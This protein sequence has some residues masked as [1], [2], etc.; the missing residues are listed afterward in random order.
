MKEILKL[1]SNTFRENGYIG[2]NITIF[3]LLLEHS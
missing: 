1:K 2:T 3:V